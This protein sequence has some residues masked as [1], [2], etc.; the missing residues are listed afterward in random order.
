VITR[1][2]TQP[3]TEPLNR[4]DV[5]HNVMLLGALRKARDKFVKAT[6][7]RLT[8]LAAI[9]GVPLITSESKWSAE[10]ATDLVNLKGMVA[11]IK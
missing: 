2:S 8:I 3:T 6:G 7:K 11:K 4:L 9:D 5:E 1:K 10:S